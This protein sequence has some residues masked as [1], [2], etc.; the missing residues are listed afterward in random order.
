MPSKHLDGILRY[1]F[2]PSKYL[3]GISRY[4]F[5][6]SKHLDGVSRYC[7]VPSKH[8]DGVSRYCFMP[9]YAYGGSFSF[10]K[11]Y[12]TCAEDLKSRPKVRHPYP[13]TGGE[14]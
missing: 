1:C 8:L 11:P 10:R 12:H 5:V 2:D 9:S 7:F 13:P 3:D 4:C 14:A 6:P